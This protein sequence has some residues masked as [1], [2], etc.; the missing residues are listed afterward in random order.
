TFDD[1]KGRASEFEV[2]QQDGVWTLPSFKGYP[3]DAKQQI[4]SAA[5]A[6]SSMKVLGKKTDDVRE[7]EELGVLEPDPS[8]E[9]SGRRGYGKLVV[10]EDEA[11]KPIARLIIG[12]K[13]KPVES[14]SFDSPQDQELRFVRVPG[15]DRVYRVAM[16]T[17]G[18]SNKF[19]DWIETDLLKINPWDITDVDL[20]DYSVSQ[21]LDP[22]GQLLIGATKRADID[23]GYDG[24]KSE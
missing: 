10:L 23:L 17:S 7:H 21:A 8:K 1:S 5:T 19:S 13:D 22:S 24:Q 9:Q 11:Q 15:R 6:I 16:S 12:K 14:D 3:A 2:A 20:R 18:L 4:I